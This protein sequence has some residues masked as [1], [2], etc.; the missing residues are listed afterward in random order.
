M[1]EYEQQMASARQ[2]AELAICS[3]AQQARI[4][5]TVVLQQSFL[6][7]EGV[8]AGVRFKWGSFTAEWLFG[9]PSL[10]LYFNGDEIAVETPISTPDRLAA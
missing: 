5:G 3:A 1:P 10:H 6:I 7:R 8:L 4:E 9:E 2:Q